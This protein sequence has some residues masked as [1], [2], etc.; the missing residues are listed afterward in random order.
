[1]LSFLSHHSTTSQLVNLSGSERLDLVSCAFLCLDRLLKVS[2][3]FARHFI[4][5]SQSIS[6]YM[7]IRLAT[8]SCLQCWLKKKR[9]E[10]KNYKR[11]DAFRIDCISFRSGNV[12]HNANPLSVYYCISI[13]YQINIQTNAPTNQQMRSMDESEWMKW[14]NERNMHYAG[15]R[16]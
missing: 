13:A 1:M 11:N 5:S 3:L 2:L 4:P 8:D 7:S 9:N 15:L 16:I 14:I 6:I 12:M 10:S